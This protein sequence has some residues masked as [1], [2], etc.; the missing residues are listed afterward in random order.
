MVPMTGI[1]KVFIQK[2]KPMGSGINET[3]NSPG[4]LMHVDLMWA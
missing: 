1:I 3:L 2:N 4:L